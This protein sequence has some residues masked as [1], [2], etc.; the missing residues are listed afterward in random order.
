[1]GWTQKELARRWGYSSNTISSWER[2]IR[3]PGIQ[4]IPRLAELLK[5]HTD[6]L[7][8]HINSHPRVES[9]QEARGTKNYFSNIGTERNFY[10]LSKPESM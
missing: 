3:I 5:L 7:A 4:Q 8:Q 9:G 10:C 6:E 2:E 1:M